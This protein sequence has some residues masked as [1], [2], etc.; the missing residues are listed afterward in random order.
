MT[1]NK[2]GTIQTVWKKKRF[3]SKNPSI[4][5]NSFR[6]NSYPNFFKSIKEEVSKI[7]HCTVVHRYLSINFLQTHESRHVQDRALS[8][9]L[10]FGLL[11]MAL[12]FQTPALII[13][14]LVSYLTFF[15]LADHRW[16]VKMFILKIGFTQ[17]SIWLTSLDKHEISIFSRPKLCSSEML[18]V[19]TN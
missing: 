19:A 5:A 11:K 4:N 16:E 13:K 2:Y 1:Q 3:D 7:A 6:N 18:I 14:I 17:T 12:F 9:W 8:A 10:W 15:F